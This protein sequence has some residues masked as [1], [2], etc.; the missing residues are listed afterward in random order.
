KPINDVRFA[1]A[2]NLDICIGCRKCVH[3]CVKE[4]NQS[5]D[6]EVQWIRVIE[7]NK[8]GFNVEHSKHDY[9]HEVPA[10]GK[11]YMPVQCHQC[12][13]PPCVRVCPTKATWRQED[14]ITV[15]DYNWCIGCRYCQAACP[16]YARRFNFSKPKIEAK[17]INPDQSYLGNRI[18]PSGVIEKCTFCAQRT[19]K[20]QMPAC[21]EACPTGA[22][23]FGDLN[24]QRSSVRY[25]LENKNVYIFKEELGTIP[26][27]FYYFDS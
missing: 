4:N 20:G 10:D 8:G 23:K 21:L 22:R 24:D 6:P 13:N 27:F 26:R 12:E 7:M 3:G 25:I 17:D 5:R 2:L 19:R 15:V 1:Y 18:R 14:G 16:Y 11:F 9:T